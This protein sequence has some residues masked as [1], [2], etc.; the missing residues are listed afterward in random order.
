M[1][2]NLRFVALHKSRTMSGKRF[3]VVPSRI[4][5]SSA[6]FSVAAL[7]CA[8]PDNCWSAAR[9]DGHPDVALR[10][11]EASRAA[12]SRSQIST[13]NPQKGGYP[14]PNRVTFLNCPNRDFPKLRRQESG[15]D[16]IHSEAFPACGPPSLLIHV[17]PALMSCLPQA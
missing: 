3:L 2:A 15:T 8:N 12:L 14:A 11:L 13:P 7:A 16:E 9:L 1:V 5:A 6:A 17:Q 10:D 4:L